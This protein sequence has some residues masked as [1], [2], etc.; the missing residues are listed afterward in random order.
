MKQSQK[1]TVIAKCHK[2]KKKKTFTNDTSLH[3]TPYCDTCFVP[4]FIDKVIVE[5]KPK[6]KQPNG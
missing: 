4:L 1:I 2:C 3:Y 6:T 5:N